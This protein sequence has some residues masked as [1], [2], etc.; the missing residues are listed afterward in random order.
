[1]F[2]DAV[3][4]ETVELVFCIQD[5]LDDPTA[6]YLFQIFNAKHTENTINGNGEDT[7]DE[8]L[9]WSSFGEQACRILRII[10]PRFTNALIYNSDTSGTKVNAIALLPSIAVTAADVGLYDQSTNPNGVKFTVKVDGSAVADP[11][12][13][14]VKIDD[15]GD[16]DGYAIYSFDDIIFPI[17]EDKSS[18]I[19]S[20]E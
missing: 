12:L 18:W 14:F 5:K 6:L 10:I 11:N 1:M 7:F 16:T 15:S 4:D 17:K 9:P 2:N 3:G 8:S 19:N 13:A 20:Q